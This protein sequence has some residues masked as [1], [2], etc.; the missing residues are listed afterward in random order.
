MQG[1][2]ET[3]PLVSCIIIFHNPVI[4]FFKTA[5]DSIIS[6][7]Y[8]NWELFLV[9]DGST[10]QSSEIALR[11]AASDPN[12]VTYLE[13]TGH[14]NCGMSSSRNLGVNNARGRYIAFLDSDD[15]WLTNKLEE[16]VAILEAY[17]NVNMVFGR[18]LIWVGWTG[19]RRHER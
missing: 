1:T 2:V 9:D 8:T 4:S 12:R 13:H 16:Q 10:N 7:T 11:Y 6:Q 15:I 17:P 5:I 14:Q 18:T 19:K 3:T